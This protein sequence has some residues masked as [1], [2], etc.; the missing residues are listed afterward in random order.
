MLGETPPDVAQMFIDPHLHGP[1][2]PAHILEATWTFE[3]I[4]YVFGGTSDKGF[5]DIGLMRSVGLK[6]T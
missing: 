5:N 6:S 2:G 3:K 1:D 4:H